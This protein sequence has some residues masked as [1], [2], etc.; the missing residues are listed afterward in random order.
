MPVPAALVP[1]AAVGLSFFVII[2][3]YFIAVAHGHV[4]PGLSNLPDITHCVLHLPAR[5]VFL[6]LF[7]PAIL[8]MA[9]SWLLAASVLAP[10]GPAL[11]LGWVAAGLGVCGCGL[12]LMGESVLDPEPNWTVHVL[13]ASGFFLITM[14]AEA[15]FA[16]AAG[17]VPAAGGRLS[18]RS[19]FAKRAVAGFN[20]FL[21][22]LD[23]VL[24]A[25]GWAKHHN[26]HLLEWILAFTVMGFH[27]SIAAD[28]RGAK[29]TM[30]LPPPVA[31]DAAAGLLT[32]SVVDASGGVQ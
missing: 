31:A 22:L 11:S 30:V 6:G 3:C 26:T 28:L 10:A 27:L 2:T 8:L 19:I 25:S 4:A 21:V 14:I 9:L 23:V 16:V 15:L 18:P 20:V 13:G 24:G 12:L 5:A 29:L 7:I 32:G 17:R 1:L